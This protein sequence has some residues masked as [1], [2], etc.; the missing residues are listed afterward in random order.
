MLVRGW[1]P[2]NREQISLL[3]L[4]YVNKYAIKTRAS[5]IYLQLEIKNTQR[6]YYQD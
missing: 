3:I 4:V 6:N 1:C 2:R 5:E